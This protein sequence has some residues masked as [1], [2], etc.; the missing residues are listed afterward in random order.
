MRGE[1]EPRFEKKGRKIRGNQIFRILDFG[2]SRAKIILIKNCDVF[3]K[4]SC[5]KKGDIG[6]RDL[7][8]LVARLDN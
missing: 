5:R 3:L 1:S 4:Q 8:S 2:Y 6:R 7:A